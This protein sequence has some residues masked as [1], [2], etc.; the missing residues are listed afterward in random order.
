VL[1]PM[2]LSPSAGDLV[3]RL[4]LT[5]LAGAAIGIN[6]GEHG[7][8]AGLRTTMLVCLA[9]AGVMIEANL[10]LPTSGKAANGFVN[11]DVMRLPLGVLTGMGFIGGG[12][13]VKRPDLVHGVTTA[14]TL[15]IVTVIGLCLGGGQ[16]ALGIA[17]SVLTLA[18]LWSLK[19]AE[20]HLRRDRWATCIISLGAEAPAEAQLRARLEASGLRIKSTA[21]TYTAEAKCR[22]Y[23]YGVEWRDSAE[24]EVPSFLSELAAQAGVQKLEWEPRGSAA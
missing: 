17:L 24:A 16:L 23:R 15:W 1:G 21:F 8:P 14:A 2:P 3:L 6:R 22:E 9:A 20:A 18:V 12:A 4:A 10:L 19:R 13:I 7:R 11:I 5:A